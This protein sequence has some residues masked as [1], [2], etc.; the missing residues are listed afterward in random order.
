MA[1]GK[2][3]AGAWGNKYQNNFFTEISFSLQI[4]LIQSEKLLQFQKYGFGIMVK[5]IPNKRTIGE[6]S[7]TN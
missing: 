7:V 3:G 2:G 4:I 5:K 6:K 1:L